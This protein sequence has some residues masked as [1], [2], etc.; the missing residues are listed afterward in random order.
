MNK[1]ISILFLFLLLACGD[2]ESCIV[3]FNES[4]EVI[5]GE[6]YCLEDGSSLEIS[7]ILS[8]YCPCNADCI[9]QGEATITA[10]RITGDKAEDVTFHEELTDDN[11]DWGSITS[12][13][14][15]ND[16]IPQIQQITIVIKR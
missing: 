9:W 5:E 15:T 7:E 3:A 1:F 13:S 12:V 14:I 11:P 16:C 6:S 10:R 8:S 4:F 2:S